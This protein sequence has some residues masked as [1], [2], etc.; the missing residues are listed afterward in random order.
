MNECQYDLKMYYAREFD[1]N[2]D[3]RTIYRWG[4]HVTNILKYNIPD[5]TAS[6]ETK[7]I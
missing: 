5:L 6:G 1:L 4:G 3:E 7:K 2:D